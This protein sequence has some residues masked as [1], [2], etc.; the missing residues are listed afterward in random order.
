MKISVIDVKPFEVTTPS[1]EVSWDGA[2]TQTIIWDKSTTDQAPINCRNV[3][4]KLS[5]DGGVTF[6]TTIVNSTPNDGIENVIIPNIPTTQARIMI[7]AVDN[8]FY[9]VNSTN[10]TIIDN[11]DAGTGDVVDFDNFNLFPNPTSDKSFNL[12]FDIEA[13][14]NVKIQLFDLRG[15]LVENR[16]FNSPTNKFAEQ[17]EYRSVNP[18]LYLLQVLKD[19]KKEVRKVIIK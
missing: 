2:T 5:T 3:R 12:I 7:E 19:G 14:S 16:E 9:N 8:I 1:T 11:P 17:L 15:R 10:F 6:P 18:G 13:Q 4:I